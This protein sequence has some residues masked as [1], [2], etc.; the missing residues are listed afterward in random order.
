MNS[1]GHLIKVGFPF[2][3]AD[4]KSL[5]ARLEQLEKAGVPARQGTV[6][7]ALVCLPTATQLFAH[8]LLLHEAQKARGGVL[9]SDYV[10][11]TIVV[12]LPKPQIEKLDSVLMD[13]ADKGVS[14]T[15]AFVLRAAF[16]ALPTGV[17]LVAFMKDFNEKFPN[18]PRGAPV[19]KLKKARKHG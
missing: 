14:T 5:D 15:R 17:G 3:P 11:D 4:L 8:A 19:A 2:Y 1:P 9:E 7:R 13:L 6:V 12:R 18:L 10:A 16:R